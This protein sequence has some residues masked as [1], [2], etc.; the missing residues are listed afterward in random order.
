M[1]YTALATLLVLGDNL[2]R[3]NRQ[4]VLDGIQRL[5]LPNGSFSSTAEGSESDMRFV[6]C[7]A[8][9]CH[10]LGDWTA[11]NLEQTTKFIKSSLVKDPKMLPCDIV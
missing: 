8:S 1:G 11:M 2:S 9:I 3:V 6:Y 4:A 5:Q 7:A 10:I